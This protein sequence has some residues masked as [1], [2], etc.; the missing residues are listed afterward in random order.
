MPHARWRV[1]VTRDDES[2]SALFQRDVDLGVLTPVSC[3]V[4]VEGPAPDPDRLAAIARQLDQY[5][6]IICVSARAVK[7]LQDASGG[8]WPKG[9]RTAAV[10]SATAAAMRAAGAEP[11]VGDAFNASALLEKLL[12]VDSWSGR[13]ALV[14]TV[15]GGRRELIDGLRAAGATVTELEAYTMQPRPAADI[16]RDWQAAQP[17]AA[18][19]G[20]AETARHLIEAVGVDALRKL[21]ALV[22]IG[23]TTAAALARAGII[24]EPPGRATFAAA[25]EHLASL[26]RR[27][28]G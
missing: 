22:P 26:S 1:A 6:W 13:R 11:L 24:A 10:G 4:L 28:S 16:L 3:P 17:D 14:T 20:S 2:T 15:A 25:V 5:D 9:P 19:I 18:V 7:P 21:K 12:S 23:P 27:G 8:V